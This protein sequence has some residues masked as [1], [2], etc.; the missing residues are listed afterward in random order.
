MCL[1]EPLKLVEILWH[2]VGWHGDTIVTPV[3]ATRAGKSPSLLPI[4][5]DIC[6]E[7][8]GPAVRA[9]R[10]NGDNSSATVQR[11]GCGRKSPSFVAKG[12]SWPVRMK[13]TK[14]KTDEP[15]S[16]S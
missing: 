9:L 11:G 12:S 8:D 15:A 3:G 10:L 2:P 5:P 6:T 4:I 1:P 13:A 14:K 7:L 16:I